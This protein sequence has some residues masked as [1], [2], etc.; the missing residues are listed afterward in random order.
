M[1]KRQVISLYLLIN[2][3]PTDIF[4]SEWDTIKDNLFTFLPWIVAFAV[5]AYVIVNIGSGGRG[6]RR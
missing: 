5:G 4:G 2:V 6:R 1:Y 3:L